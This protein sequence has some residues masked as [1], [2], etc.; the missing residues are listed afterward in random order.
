VRFATVEAGFWPIA[1]TDG[2]PRSNVKTSMGRIFV[3]QPNRQKYDGATIITKRCDPY[4]IQYQA[5]AERQ[6]SGGT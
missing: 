1:G 3:L 6:I 2:M 4:F 5:L